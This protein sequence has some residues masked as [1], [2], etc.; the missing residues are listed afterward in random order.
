MTPQA[1]E[2]IDQVK[3]ELN[4]AIHIAAG[5]PLSWETSQRIWACI[6]K[7]SSASC[8]LDGLRFAVGIPKDE[9]ETGR[10]VEPVECK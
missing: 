6:N 5:L 7:I 10:W 4:D 2:I 3:T 8:R 9:K 1:Q